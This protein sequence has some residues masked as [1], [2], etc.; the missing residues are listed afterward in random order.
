M[1]GAIEH[2]LAKIELL[3][4]SDSPDRRT[5]FQLGYNLGRLSELA[6]LGREPC[7]DRWQ[8]LVDMWDSDRTR[9]LAHEL[10]NLVAEQA[11]PAPST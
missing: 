7:W 10:R 5:L 9:R 2:C 4:A 11:P 8:E 1:S 3:A 6:Q